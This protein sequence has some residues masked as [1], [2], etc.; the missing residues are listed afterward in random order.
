MSARIEL[1][2]ITMN[3]PV[4]KLLGRKARPT[5][6]IDTYGFLDGW[7]IGYKKKSVAVDADDVST[8][9]GWLVRIRVRKS[10]NR[11]VGD[12]YFL[13]GLFNR[14]FGGRISHG[15][16]LKACLA[17]GI[18]FSRSGA[19]AYIGLSSRC[20]LLRKILRQRH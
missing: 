10:A 7:E 1:K 5:P 9:E 17:L 16:F 19:Y 20:G 11:K 14:Y 13:C 4:K 15:A 3:S 6:L 2:R 8:A 12:S 18:P